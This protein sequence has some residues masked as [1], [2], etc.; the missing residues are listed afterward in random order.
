[1]TPIDLKPW[2]STA[3]A[4]SPTARPG[5]PGIAAGKPTPMRIACLLVRSLALRRIRVSRETC[6][7][8]NEA[9]IYREWEPPPEW[10]HA[11]ACLWEQRVGVE[12]VQRV[13]PDGHAD[14]LVH[15]SGV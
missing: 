15:D 1:M 6:G 2:Y 14:L 9:D 12:R 13:V 4:Q 5:T 10:R 3:A 7:V 11:V 8:L